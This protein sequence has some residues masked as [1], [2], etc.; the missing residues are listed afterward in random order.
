VDYYSPPATPPLGRTQITVRHPYHLPL[1][2]VLYLGLQTDG[3]KKA[4][5]EFEH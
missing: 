5:V 1:N 2:E 4:R 3:L